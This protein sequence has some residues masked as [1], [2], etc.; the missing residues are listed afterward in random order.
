MASTVAACGHGDGAPS[1]PPPSQAG[2]LEAPPSAIDVVHP[3]IAVAPDS[4]PAADPKLDGFDGWPLRFDADHALG[5]GLSC[6]VTIAR[7]GTSLRSLTG[8]LDASGCMASW[9]GRD[10]S[11]AFVTPGTASVAASL[12]DGSGTTRARAT[13][14]IEVVRVGISEVQLSA[15]DTGERVSLLYPAVGG[16]RGSFYEEPAG[17]APFHMAP[18]GNEGA[19]AVAL[20]LANGAPRPVPPPWSDLRSPPL[21]TASADGVEDGT[22]NLPTAWVA[23]S[24]VRAAATLSAS[25]VDSPTGTPEAAVLRV[26]PPEGTMLATGDTAFADGATVTVDTETSPVPAVGRYDLSLVWT[27]EV[28]AADGWLPIPGA[29]TTVHRLYGLAGEPTFDYSSIPHRAWVDVVDRVTGWVDGTTSDPSTVAG[30]IVD[31]VYHDL[32]LHYDRVHGAS[33][34][35]T[36]PT[37]TFAGAHFDLSH[38]EDLSYGTTINCSDAA[39]IVSTYADMVGVDLRY[40]ILQHRTARAFD[41]N[42]IEAIG[43]TGFT[44]T[45]FTSGA[46]AFSYHAVTGPPDGTFYDATLALDGDGDPLSLPSTALLAEGMAP[47]DYLYDLSSEWMQIA[48]TEDQKVWVQ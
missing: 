25:S 47:N 15:G 27:F 28:R 11:G 19:A 7:D 8:L 24:I 45:P 40:H 46:G 33:A 37:A 42:F 30:D 36:Y 16:T 4:L 32:G 26:V 31:H 35:T 1:P 14:A 18:D 3:S 20:E 39:S 38:F 17:T 5:R 44:E 22:F 13:A 41:L 6:Q 48:V 2:V 9:D 43:T 10:G 12:V 29:V 34:Y 23:G 21:D